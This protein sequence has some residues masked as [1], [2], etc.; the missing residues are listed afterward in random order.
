[1]ENFWGR[2]KN[3]KPVRNFLL[4]LAVM[5]PGVITANVDN[6]AGGIAT[7]SIAGAYPFGYSCLWT[8]FPII[9]LL[10]LTQE[11]GFRMGAVTGKG[12]A[13]LIRERS[14]LRLTFYL[15]IALLIANIGNA[16]A[17]FSGVAAS[18]E[19]Y[20]ISKYASVPCA[21]M[22]V[23]LL[24]VKGSYRVVEKVFIIACLFYI[25]YIVSGFMAK[26][27]WSEVGTAIILPHARWNAEYLYMVAGL[28]GATVAPWMQFYVQSAVVEKGV[29]ADDYRIAR[30]DVIIGCIMA[31]VVVFFIIVAC[32]ATVGKAGIRVESAT[33]A[34]IALQ[35]LAGKY[36]SMLFSFGLFTASLFAAAV[37]PLTTAY[38]ICE[39]LGFETG[40]NKTFKEAPH[41]YGLY[42]AII[43]IGACTVLWPNFPLFRVMVFSQVINAFLL[44]FIMY[45][46][47]TLASSKE[48][49]GEFANTPRM[50]R[51][52]Y[53]V[54][55]LLTILNASLIY[56]SVW[57]S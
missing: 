17:E 16:M 13:D 10:I 9:I 19:L 27:D 44:P 40:V 47:V 57:S 18:L 11:M 36:A 8:L 12:L 23:W 49:M 22:A 31:H 43:A 1:M 54:T 7:Y 53:G 55:V 6:D 56:L 32:G 29:A 24:V 50:N 52:S 30:W 37:L 48:I 28:I 15:M 33:E 41:F 2:I 4:F 34:A 14:G 46:V 42:T 51:I 5:G 39:G 25:A 35:P 26:P 3:L 38:T 21:A 45:H 20:G